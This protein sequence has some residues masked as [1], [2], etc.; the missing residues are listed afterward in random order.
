MKNINILENIKPLVVLGVLSL[1]VLACSSRDEN[2]SNGVNAGNPEGTFISFNI[3]GIAEEGNT[4]D[5]MH[6]SVN[7][8]ADLSIKPIASGTVNQIVS[9]DDFDAV[10]SAEGSQAISENSRPN[11]SLANIYAGAAVATTTQ[12]AVGTKYRLLIYN[13]NVLIKNIDATAGT[14]INVTVDAGKQYKWYVISTNDTT[15]PAVDTTTGIVSGTAL[16]NKDILY[17]QGVI[18]AQYGENTLNISFKHHTVRIEVDLDTRGMFGTISG[19]TSME[20]GSGAGSAFNSIIKTGDLNLFTGQYSNFQTLSALTAA[21]MI[22]KPGA[23]GTTGATK[24][25]AFFTVNT[26]TIPVNN[27]K[28]KLGKLDL[29]MDNNSGRSYTNS[30]L[31]YNNTVL[32]P[33]LGSRYNLTARLV[34]SGVRVRGLL[35]A[36]TNLQYDA[37]QSDMYRFRVDND[38]VNPNSE[39][40]YWNWKSATPTGSSADNVDPCTKVYPEGMWRMPTSTEF[41][42][43]GNPDKK[44][45]NYGLIAGAV[46]SGVW[47]LDTGNTVN[48]VFPANSQNLFMSLYGYRTTPGI[49]G[50]S[51]KDSPAGLVLGV[52]GFGAAH[53]WTSTPTDTNNANYYYISYSRLVLLVGWSNSEIRSSA[54]GEGRSVRCVRS[55]S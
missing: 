11:A 2:V 15:T 35:W 53:Y 3:S 25:A 13:N 33:A 7:K 47:N 21:N 23:G 26:T 40:E 51:I 30:I 29:S 52:L 28:I 41:D 49:F 46:F 54:K 39:S 27:L 1:V 4:S 20:I 12:M 14:A 38:Y 31:S 5:I 55:A 16:A 32:T 24:T 19:T 50:T 34:E 9:T 18:D 43:V 8:L 48:T 10:I 6:A 45:E 44:N 22:N 42:T 37:S 36:R 17:N